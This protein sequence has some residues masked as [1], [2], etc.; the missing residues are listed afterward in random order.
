MLSVAGRIA[1][2]QL[3]AALAVK[4]RA[5]AFNLVAT[6]R[7]RMRR[8]KVLALLAGAMVPWPPMALG[9]SVG[10]LRNIGVLMGLAET[11]PEIPRRLA[12]FRQALHDP[13]WVEGHNIL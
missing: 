13:G 4:T 7:Y 1:F 5:L 9:Q 8:R 11:G 2:R 10:R 12:I 3:E 6:A